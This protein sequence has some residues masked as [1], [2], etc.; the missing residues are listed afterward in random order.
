MAELTL[1][2]HL[3]RHLR[4]LRNSCELFDRGDADE[5]IRIAVELRVLMH[6]SGGTPLLEQLEKTMQPNI[7]LL[8]TSAD[9]GPNVMAAVGSLSSSRVTL[10]DGK[11]V[12]THAPLI[13]RSGIRNFMPW[14]DWWAQPVYLM[15]GRYI[16]RGEIASDAANKE[17][18]HIA[19]KLP[20]AYKALQAGHTTIDQHRDGEFIAKIAL[21]DVHLYDLRQMAHEVISSPDL[22]V[23]V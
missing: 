6:P 21:E 22:V 9:I 8:S 1:E 5:G 15:S 3:S 18:A 20:A 17:G 19:P 23:H 4:F 7:R 2:Q 13:D 12:A 11:V 10:Q 14:R 16:S